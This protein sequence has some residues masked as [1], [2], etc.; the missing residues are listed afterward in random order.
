MEKT[1]IIKIVTILWMVAATVYESNVFSDLPEINNWFKLATALLLMYL[2]YENG[3]D[4]KAKSIG[5]GGIKNPP[6]N[7]P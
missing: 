2:N 1:K 5:G 4:V 7:K 6:P 3:K